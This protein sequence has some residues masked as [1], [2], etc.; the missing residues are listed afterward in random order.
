MAT[1][2][3]NNKNNKNNTNHHGKPPL[4]S[5]S[6]NGRSM[7]NEPV[8]S[9][10]LQPPEK[11]NAWVDRPDLYRLLDKS[12]HKKL[13]LILAP[14]GSGK[15]TLLSQWY[16]RQPEGEHRSWLSLDTFDDNFF[17]FY[18]YL[19]A[20]IR[21]A[22]QDFE[23]TLH[24]Q[25]IHLPDLPTAWINESILSYFDGLQAP[26]T[27]VIDDFQVIGSSDLL[28]GMAALI[29]YL[30]P[31]VHV[32]L[33]TRRHPDL[34]L[35][36]LKLDDELLVIDAHDL[37]F[38]TRDIEALSVH[39]LGYELEQA[40]NNELCTATEGW[41]TGVKL[42]L[43]SAKRSRVSDWS[44]TQLGD[45]QHELMNYFAEV[46]LDQ[47]SEAVAHFLMATALVD[48]LHPDLC[49]AL[50][51]DDQ[52]R[53]ILFDLYRNHLFI[54]AEDGRHQWFRYHS[55]FR[56][57]LLQRLH[58]VEQPQ[59]QLW[60]QRA[61]A[62]YLDQGE[63]RQALQH[64]LASEQQSIIEE[65]AAAMAQNGLREGEFDAVI[66][67]V[68]QLSQ[69]SDTELMWRNRL[70][71]AEAYI[72]SLLFSR[73]FEDVTHSLSL[74]EAAC[75]EGR[76]DRDQWRP[77]RDIIRSIL[78]MFVDDTGFGMAFQP[79]PQEPDSANNG[80]YAFGQAMLSYHYLQQAHYVPARVNA[81][82]ARK[83]LD[84]LE[85]ECLKGYCELLLTQLDRY[86]GQQ[87]HAVERVERWHQWETER[88]EFSASWVNSATAL[89]VVR[90]EQNQ[91][92]EAER[93]CL[94]VLPRLSHACASE[95][96]TAAYT[97]LARIKA[98]KGNWREA[99]QLTDYLF[100]IL[101][102]GQYQRF[103]AAVCVEKMR[104]AK[105]EGRLDLA[106]K[107]VTD[108]SLLQSGKTG[109][110]H[111][112]VVDENR[113]LALAW[114]CQMIGE[115][116]QA[117]AVFQQQSSRA[118]RAGNIAR[119]TVHIANDCLVRWQQGE[120]KAVESQIRE[121]IQRV[122]W[123]NLNRSVYDEAPGFGELLAELVA[124]RSLRVEIPDLYR[125]VFHDVLPI[126]KVSSHCL[127]VE[128]LTEKETEILNWL[129]QGYTNKEISRLTAIQL[130]TTKWHVKNI[131]QKLSVSNRTEAVRVGEKLGLLHEPGVLKT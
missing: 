92:A 50:V 95:V 26:Y 2:N 84:Q 99:W 85:Y 120:C 88:G 62:W 1:L 57:F 58:Q 129:G 126:E 35:S 131:F 3:K 78:R 66:E 128:P 61:A 54:T 125:E 22:F 97:T 82:Q 83:R 79:L 64:A 80:L 118:G 36:K 106:E 77:K 49:A 29:R 14:A 38:D 102:N 31:H 41:V 69:H 39:L 45:Y 32:I 74:M 93:L 11:M 53:S 67:V 71:L 48:R 60:H 9:A 127:L 21:S 68:D 47:Q 108:F 12:Q 115:P 116:T 121:L 10:K 100:G 124:E 122:S 37:R 55:V 43:L 86:E 42:A 15:T 7:A 63:Y 65:T 59:I 87:L 6:E 112:D 101:D 105:Q 19:C 75:E 33:A 110:E 89:A 34:A 114:W 13:T 17:R 73:R 28:E 130:S 113:S 109:Q 90:Y 56:E 52:G 111:Y 8:A 117:Q 23:I 81:D 27:L 44:L 25:S 119:E 107:V 18:R 98:L 30:P 72:A 4:R 94:E 16:H 5:H 70:E 123:V 24:S 40:L 96:I 76:V 104:I 20:S 103:V 46:V 51:E 91:L